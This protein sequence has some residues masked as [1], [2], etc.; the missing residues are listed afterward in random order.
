MSKRGMSGHRQA[1]RENNMKANREKAAEGKTPGTGAPS[2]PQIEPALSCL[3]LS[4]PASRA[5]R[6]AVG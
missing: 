3:D 2:Q 1:K 5:V 4:L 6:R